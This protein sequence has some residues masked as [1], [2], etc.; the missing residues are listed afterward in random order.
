MDKSILTWI[1]ILIVFTTL[2]FFTGKCSKSKTVL[3]DTAW[4]KPD[5]ILK[6]DTIRPQAEIKW[7]P[8][9]VVYIP[10][11]VKDT[12]RTYE[13]SIEDKNLK[14]YVREMI[15]NKGEL[16]GRDVGYKLFVPLEIKTTEII[17]QPVL[18]IEP[19]KRFYIQAGL[20]VNINK[21]PISAEIGT[22][23]KNNLIGIQYIRYSK[24]NI[25]LLKY[26][27]KF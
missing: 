25:F 14:I 22:I 11:S 12:T 18:Y 1:S 3:Q 13:D 4:L 16:T 24:E 21:I 17:T 19:P 10:I 23:K 5:T 26:G 2:G 20:G 6:Y 7:L 15:T 27:L 8:G 9:K